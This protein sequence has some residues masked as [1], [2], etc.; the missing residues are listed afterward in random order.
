[1]TFH[2]LFHKVLKCWLWLV[3]CVSYN[4]LMNKTPTLFFSLF[5]R[6]TISRGWPE[7]DLMLQSIL[8]VRAQEAYSALSE[9][10]GQKYSAVKDAVLKTYEPVPEAYL[11]HFRSWRKSDKQSHVELARDLIKH[12]NRWCSALELT[13]LKDLCDLMVLEQFKDY[14][15][16][17]VAAHIAEK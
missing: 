12:L 17:E 1:M 6:V 13:P 11:Q 5:E 7:A 2:H 10:G 3:T 14:I 16:P 8:T 4:S 9:V 15:Q